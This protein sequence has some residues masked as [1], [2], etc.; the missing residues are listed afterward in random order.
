MA[1]VA[2]RYGETDTA[3]KLL[4]ISVDGVVVVASIC[5]IELTSRIAGSHR[6][7]GHQADQPPLDEVREGT[8]RLPEGEP[9]QDDADHDHESRDQADVAPVLATGDRPICD[10]PR[11]PVRADAASRHT[12]ARPTDR[13]GT[14]TGERAAI[15]APAQP[16]MTS[17]T[18]TKTQSAEPRRRSA[19]SQTVS[20]RPARARATPPNSADR[21]PAAPGATSAI[22]TRTVSPTAGSFTAGS[23]TAGSPTAA[24]PTPGSPA[25]ASTRGTPT[26]PA[27]P[28]AGPGSAEYEPVSADDAVMY[29]TWLEAVATGRTPTGVELARAAGRSNDRSGH[30]RRAIRRYRDAHT[31]PSSGASSISV[32]RMTRRRQFDRT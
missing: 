25:A 28:P 2:A 24:S 7:I 27:T 32:G 26:G 29:R 16:D 1:G 14:G 17:A 12:D 31:V 19:P 22:T 3:A 5:L 4:P 18:E 21:T 6:P 10:H 20:T 23:F 30:G 9:P 13:S 15:R 11:S 8:A